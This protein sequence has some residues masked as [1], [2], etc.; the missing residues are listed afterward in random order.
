LANKKLLLLS[1]EQL[2]ARSETGAAAEVAPVSG[3]SLLS[4]VRHITTASSLADSR[5]SLDYE[6]FEG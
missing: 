4:Q 2:A 1:S 5:W 6:T 3:S